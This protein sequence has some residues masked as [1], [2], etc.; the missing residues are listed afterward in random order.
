LEKLPVAAP[1]ALQPDAE[2]VMALFQAIF[3]IIQASSP[4]DM[5]ASSY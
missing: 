5:C 1:G 4:M 2:P 3:S